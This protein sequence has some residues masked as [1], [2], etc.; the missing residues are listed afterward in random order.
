MAFS[1][2]TQSRNLP[3]SLNPLKLDQAITGLFAIPNPDA[4][5]P[6]CKA[7]PR[8]TAKE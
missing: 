7:P 3:V 5:K 1:E 2:K 6:K 8:T 4:T